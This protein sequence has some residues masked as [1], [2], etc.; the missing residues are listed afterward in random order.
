MPGPEG[1]LARGV[2]KSR[3][4]SPGLGSIWLSLRLIEISSSEVESEGSSLAEGIAESR[5]IRQWISRELDLGGE[6][7]GT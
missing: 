6:V 2:D 4:A 7:V 5:P 1:G 3:G